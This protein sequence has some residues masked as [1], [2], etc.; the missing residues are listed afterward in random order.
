MGTFWV[1]IGAYTCLSSTILLT[2]RCHQYVDRARLT[3]IAVMWFGYLSLSFRVFIFRL[4]GYLHF[5]LILWFLFYQFRP[6]HFPTCLKY[7]FLKKNGLIDGYC[8]L[9]SSRCRSWLVARRKKKSRRKQ[10]FHLTLSSLSFFSRP[11]QL[12]WSVGRD[13]NVNGVLPYWY[14]IWRIRWAARYLYHQS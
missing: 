1:H 3:N 13:L 4:L 14:G 11:Y 7:M 12:A 8:L 6:A 10:H 5:S 2:H 9:L